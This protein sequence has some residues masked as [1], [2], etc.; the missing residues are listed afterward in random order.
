MLSLKVKK[1]TAVMLG[2]LLVCLAGCSSGTKGKPQVSQVPVALIGDPFAVLQAEAGK[3]LRQNRPL[4]IEPET[5]YEKIVAGAD[6]NYYLVDIRNDEHYA[7]AHIAGAIHIAYA[8]TWREQKIEYLPKDKKI[9]VIDYSGHTA[10]QVAAFWNMLG[11]DAIAMK[12][13]M[14]GW[15]KN[16]ETIGGSPL[17]CEAQGYPV[18]TSVNPVQNFDLPAVE[19]KAASV[20]ELLMK[21]SRE[22]VENLPVIQPKDLKEKLRNYYIVDLRQPVHYQTG[23]IDGAISIPFQTIVET[24]NLKKIPPDKEVVLVCYDGHASSQA[25]RI[26]NQLG[27]HALALKDGMGAWLSDERIIGG[28]AVACNAAEKPVMKLNA[29]LKPGPAAAAT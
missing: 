3:Y 16:K 17:L 19:T 23:H 29:V 8:D 12:N 21:R 20:A 11:L 6:S 27:Y 26:L 28:K 15:S 24:D 22:A 7:N 1:I 2:V 25:A 10:S 9:I 5:V 4:Y 18:V 13:G 14:A